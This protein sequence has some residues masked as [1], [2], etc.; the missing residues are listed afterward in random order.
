MN[1]QSGLTSAGSL[2]FGIWL[3]ILVIVLI[4]SGRVA[5]RGVG[6]ESEY[7]VA[8]RKVPL[9]LSVLALLAT[10][11]GSSSVIE[12][13][14]KMYQGGLG[15]VLLDPIACGATLILTGVLFAERFWNSGSST[16]A[17]LFRKQ[18]GVS[19]ERLSCLIQVPSFFLWIG[20]QFLAMGQILASTLGLPLWIGIAVSGLVTLSIVVWGGMWSVTWANSI[21][22]LVSLASVLVLFVATGTTI[23]GGSFMTGITRVL[24]AAPQTHMQFDGSSPKKF[25]AIASVLVIGLLGNV[26]GQDIQ[27]RVASAA[28]ARTARWMCI[29]AGVL[30]L[31]LGAI[32]LYLGLAA[33]Y[34]FGDRLQETELPIHHLAGVYLSQPLQILL[35]VGMY[36][37]CLAVAAGATLSQSSI[38][39]QNLLKSVWSGKG[40]LIDS[41]N[42]HRARMSVIMVVVGSIAV[43]YSGESIMGLL[44]LSLVIVL[45]SLFVPLFIALFFP[46]RAPRPW[47]GTAAMIMGL[48]A[49]L[50]GLGV[51]EATGIPASLL[52]LLT[53]CIAGGVAM[54]RYQGVW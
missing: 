3:A 33:R 30:Y 12:S 1:S 41:D 25:M 40:N 20:S 7:L 16:V 27:Q 15:Q 47:V 17:D 44:E 21:M 23:G 50:L 43:A 49:W 32:P 14:T 52:G 35:L 39:S 42:M 46:T 37:L 10:W 53:S 5:S 11:F 54:R 34:R 51:E 26:P 18:F 48:T 2:W 4:L 9:V 19:T 36:S 22:I 28:S 31:L 6:T 45:V 29:I 38:V 13:S 24:E 8:G